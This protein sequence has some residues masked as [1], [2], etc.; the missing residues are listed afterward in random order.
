MP[1]ESQATKSD[2]PDPKTI[3]LKYTAIF[4]TYVF[5]LGDVNDR[6]KRV[7]GD[8]DAT[9]FSATSFFSQ[10]QTPAVTAPSALALSTSDAG[11][12]GNRCE[13]EREPDADIQQCAGRQRAVQRVHR[14]GDGWH[15]GDD[16]KRIPEHRRDAED[17][18]F[19]PGKQPDGIH[20]A[21]HRICGGGY[22]W[23]APDGDRELHYG[24]IRDGAHAV[25]PYKNLPPPPGR[26]Q[27]TDLPLQN[28]GGGRGKM[29]EQ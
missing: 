21:Y 19:R 25:R 6:V 24:V 23:P 4:T 13:R 18:H 16:G 8:S 28:G 3:Q 29:K 9:N 26:G 10:V 12:C 5:D 1:A 22:L 2:T 11:G 15:A 27:V 20:G 14:K 7:I 17:H